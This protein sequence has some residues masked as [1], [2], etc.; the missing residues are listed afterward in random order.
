MAK[1]IHRAVS[2]QYTG[3]YEYRNA[4][5]ATLAMQAESTDAGRAALT[6]FYVDHDPRVTE[7]RLQPDYHHL[8]PEDM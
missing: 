6:P 4:R 3:G 8:R 7:Q 1:A 2:T 5:P